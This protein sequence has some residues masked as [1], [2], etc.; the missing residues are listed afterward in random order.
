M[1]E[2]M[3]IVIINDWIS[4]ISSGGTYRVQG[5]AQGLT[6]LGHKVLICTPYGVVENLSM[7]INQPNIG[8]PG[9]YLT[10][11]FPLIFQ[12]LRALI[13]KGLVDL[14]IVEMPSP[15]TKALLLI[16]ELKLLNIPLI[17]DFADPWWRFSTNAKVQVYNAIAHKLASLQARHAILVTSSS[18]LI[19][20]YIFKNMPILHIPNGVDISLFKHL[21]DEEKN[22]DETLIGVLGTFNKR[23]GSEILIPLLRTLSKKGIKARMLLVGGGEN[24]PKIQKEVFTYELQDRILIAGSVK[25]GFIPKLLSKADILLAPYIETPEMHFIFPTK[26]PEMMALRRPVITAKLYEILT[27]FKVGKELLVASYDV[28]D[29]AEKIESLIKDPG[30]AEDIAKSAYRKVLSDMLWEKLMCK[31]LGKIKSM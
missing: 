2:S 12:F 27:T 8:S 25:R 6:R 22:T 4:N 11:T 18:K 5:F 9:Y 14:V 29:Y 28:K 7:Q 17:L 26:V 23:N 19:L 10:T 16:P 24:L 20:R 13:K 1:K 3:N 31:L 15:I 21:R 30:L